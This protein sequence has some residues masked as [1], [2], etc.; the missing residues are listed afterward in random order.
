MDNEW[1]AT[2]LNNQHPRH[3]GGGGVPIGRG[4]VGIA[5]VVLDEEVEVEYELA[6]QV[7]RSEEAQVVGEVVRRACGAKT[8]VLR[9]S[10]T[11]HADARPAPAK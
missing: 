9:P 8:D 2:R 10:E 6:E 1:R 5:V 11:H 3:Q 4:M 7:V